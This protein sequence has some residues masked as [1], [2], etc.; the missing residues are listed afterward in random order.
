MKKILSFLLIIV[1]V[2]SL[3]GCSG[4]KC[5]ICGERGDEVVKV[6]KYSYRGTKR[7]LCEICWLDYLI[8]IQSEQIEKYY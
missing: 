8:D 2:F 3:S 1:F 5:S 4:H 6:K 7:Y